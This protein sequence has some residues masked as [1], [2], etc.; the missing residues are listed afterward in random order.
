[1]KPTLVNG[2]PNVT[3]SHAGKSWLRRVHTLVLDAFVGPRPQGMVCCHIDG[4]RTNNLLSNLRW[5]T[6]SE[7][8]YDIVR[9]GH[10]H[11]AGKT[12]CPRGHALVAP[13]LVHGSL[14]RGKRECRACNQARASRRTGAAFEAAAQAKYM[15]LMGAAGARD[16]WIDDD[17]EERDA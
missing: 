5:G 2:Y 15:S 7:N 11:D 17:E 12:H 3:L 4:V 14:A 6:S 13:N 9:H 1:M 16:I 8:N 10:H